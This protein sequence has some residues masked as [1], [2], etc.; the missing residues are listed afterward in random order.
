MKKFEELELS[1]K[2]KIAFDVFGR[3]LERIENEIEQT[4]RQLKKLKREQKK[5]NEYI[6]LY[7]DVERSVFGA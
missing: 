2:C 6:N 7:K 5:Y 3:E 4:E 1:E